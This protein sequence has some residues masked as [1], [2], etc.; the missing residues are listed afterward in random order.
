MF[1]SV[2]GYISGA[3]YRALQLYCFKI[4]MPEDSSP[5]CPDMK[6]SRLW[7][8]SWEACFNND[9]LC[10]DKISK[11]IRVVTFVQFIQIKQSAFRNTSGLWRICYSHCNS[12]F[13]MLHSFHT[14]LTRWAVLETQ[15]RTLFEFDYFCTPLPSTKNT[16]T[17][18]KAIASIR[19]I[20]KQEISQSISLNVSRHID[21]R[22]TLQSRFH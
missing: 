9:I 19:W 17:F 6:N 11:L 5:S 10:I 4:K 8:L 12:H 1:C 13:N 20:R 7:I 22:T 16:F 2:Y 15:L 18:W 14:F 3:R 21:S